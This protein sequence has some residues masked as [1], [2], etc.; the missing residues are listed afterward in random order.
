MSAASIV[1]SAC[2]RGV[3]RVVA[4]SAPFVPKS[5]SSAPSACK[6]AKFILP[7]TASYT[8]SA[9]SITAPATTA[10][11]RTR[12]GCSCVSSSTI[13]A[14]ARLA[15]SP[16]GRRLASAMTACCRWR[17]KSSCSSCARSQ[18]ICSSVMVAAEIA[19][20][21]FSLS[22]SCARSVSFRFSKAATAFM[23]VPPFPLFL[24]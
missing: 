14:L 6:S 1:V 23:C 15:R 12:L 22:S 18:A 11:R 19:C 16:S 5:I 4:V 2:A 3:C 8:A 9:A 13:C 7:F 10:P 21:I 24:G 20:G 17:A